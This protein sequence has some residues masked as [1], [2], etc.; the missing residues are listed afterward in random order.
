MVNCFIP[1]RPR[2]TASPKFELPFNCSSLHPDQREKE[3]LQNLYNIY[4]F[5]CLLTMFII[6]RYD[7]I[8]HRTIITF[9]QL[10]QILLV[11]SIRSARLPHDKL[12]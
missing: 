2:D 4:Y 11:D 5:H 8:I 9:H 10:P 12:L 6:D 7:Y 1:L 3:K